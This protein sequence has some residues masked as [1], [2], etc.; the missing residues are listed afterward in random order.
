MVLQKGQ[1][2]LAGVT[3]ALDTPKIAGYGPFRNDAPKLQ[4]LT[5]DPRCTPAGIFFR[6]ASDQIADLLAD[7]RAAAP[8]AG[9]PA[10]VE[11]KTGAVPGDDSF[12]L[13]DDEDLF[14]AGPRASEKRPVQAV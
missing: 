6:Q 9:P 7:L 13:H 1:P 4:K 12:G 8:R 14:P 2:A 10:P 3:P 11:P 5:V